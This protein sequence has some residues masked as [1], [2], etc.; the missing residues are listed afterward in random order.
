MRLF[1]ELTMRAQQE[2][3]KGKIGGLNPEYTF[4]ELQSHTQST[5]RVLKGNMARETCAQI[6]V[7]V[8]RGHFHEAVEYLKQKVATFC[9]SIMDEKHLM[10]LL[11]LLTGYEERTR[12]TH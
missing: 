1:R 12:V 2:F 5:S 3:E 6:L 11:G 4:G 9:L 7:R 8:L 10:F